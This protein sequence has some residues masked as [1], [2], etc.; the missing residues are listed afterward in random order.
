[1]QCGVP[2][3]FRGTSL[4][5]NKSFSF[6]PLKN[7]CNVSQC[8]RLRGKFIVQISSVIFC[9]WNALHVRRDMLSLYV[10]VLTDFNTINVHSIL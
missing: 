6:F 9:L 1:M 2:E 10:F 3:V 8:I 7:I 4:V 5:L